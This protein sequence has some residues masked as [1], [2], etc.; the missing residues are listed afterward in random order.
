MRLAVSDFGKSRKVH[1][2]RANAALDAALSSDPEFAAAMEDL[3]PGVTQTVARAKGRTNPPE[4]TWHHA[5]I[6][7]GRGPGV[8]QLVPTAQHASRSAFQNVLHEGGCGGY[9]EWAKPAGAP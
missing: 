5:N 9:A 8:M 4:W 2:Q 3:I 7:H 6:Q 1:F